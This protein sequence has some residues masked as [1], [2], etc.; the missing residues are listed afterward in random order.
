METDNSQL[1]D[2]P[3]MG[4]PFRN[5]PFPWTPVKS[6]IYK[7]KIFQQITRA[8]FKFYK[9]LTEHPYSNFDV[10]WDNIRPHI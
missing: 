9:I 2:T 5:A 7:S 6:C 10:K 4:F 1:R 3:F 8:H